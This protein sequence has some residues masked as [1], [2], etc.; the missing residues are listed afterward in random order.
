MLPVCPRR[1]ILLVGAP[2]PHYTG[3]LEPGQEAGIQGPLHERLS[4]GDPTLSTASTSW[5][6]QSHQLLAGLVHGCGVL[7]DLP[8]SNAT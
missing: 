5:M 7:K 2:H 4:P 6:L 8:A 1:L 3:G